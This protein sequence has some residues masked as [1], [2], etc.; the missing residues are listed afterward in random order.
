M[1]GEDA[2]TRAAEERCPAC[3]GRGWRWVRRT[4]AEMALLLDGQ[5][6]TLVR[7]VCPDCPAAS[8]AA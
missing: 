8:E 2:P 3:R 1:I 6:V 5:A 7:V 4:R